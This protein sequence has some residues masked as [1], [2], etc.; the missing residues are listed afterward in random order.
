MRRELKYG[1][2]SHPTPHDPVPP[3]RQD[4]NYMSEIGILFDLLVAP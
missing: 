2:D 1:R 3:R 4:T